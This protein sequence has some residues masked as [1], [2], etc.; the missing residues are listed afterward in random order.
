MHRIEL[1]SL[2]GMRLVWFHITTRN[3]R[4]FT[5]NDFLL[6]SSKIP[7]TTW[8]RNTKA[9]AKV[10]TSFPRLVVVKIQ[11]CGGDCFFVVCAL[12]FSNPQSVSLY[13]MRYGF[14]SLLLFRLLYL[15][16]LSIEV[17]DENSCSD[18]DRIEI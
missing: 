8:P 7:S 11:A 9:K 15:L 3:L 16:R 14:L 18:S 6:A 2:L 5:R 13:D 10:Y 4:A 1:D 17:W 12:I